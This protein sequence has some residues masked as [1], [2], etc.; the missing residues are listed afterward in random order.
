[1]SAHSPGPWSLYGGY[2]RAGKRTIAHVET[3]HAAP[4]AV[5]ANA[6]LIA[7]APEMLE[8]LRDA[9][10]EMDAWMLERTP[11]ADDIDEMRSGFRALIAKIETG[12]A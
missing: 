5:E 6:R 9:V 4:L 1:M 12:W 8:A 2:V 10:E 7:A 3:D 11:D